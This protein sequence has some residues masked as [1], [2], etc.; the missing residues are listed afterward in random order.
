MI[1]SRS[2]AYETGE[3]LTVAVIVNWPQ[4]DPGEVV[5][6]ALSLLKLCR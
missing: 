4:T 5:A 6:V 1:F 3:K 2:V